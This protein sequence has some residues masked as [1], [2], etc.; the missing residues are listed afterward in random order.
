MHA[1][2][3]RVFIIDSAC[4]EGTFGVDLLVRDGD[5]MSLDLSFGDAMDE[6]T[7]D[8]RM[9]TPIMLG[10]TL[11]AGPLETACFV[12]FHLALYRKL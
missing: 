11:A 3:E 6:H 4:D 9:R 8:V 12:S 10:L 7:G 1:A 2:D 5:D